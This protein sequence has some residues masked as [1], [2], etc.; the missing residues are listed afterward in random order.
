MELRHLRYFV[1]VAEEENISRAAV[2]LNI[3]QPPL[4]RQIRNLEEELGVELFTRAAKSIQLTDPGKIFLKEAR[5]ILLRVDVAIGVVQAAA[6]E[7][8]K[9]LFIGYAPSPTSDF[10]SAILNEFKNR[11]PEIHVRLHD[12]TSIEMLKAL[13]AKRISAGL[14]VE[15]EGVEKNGLAFRPLRSY[16]AGVI[17][18]RSHPFADRTE[19]SIEELLNEPM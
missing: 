3:S 4:S 7:Q 14:L 9:E 12:M 10:L 17:V 16:P 8:R 5:S 19:I 13:R 6:K 11:K 1:A 18:A 2:R 15:Q